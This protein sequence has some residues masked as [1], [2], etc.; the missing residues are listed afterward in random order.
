MSEEYM[1]MPELQEPV[2]MSSQD[3]HPEEEFPSED[4]EEDE[5]LGFSERRGNDGIFQLLHKI[6]NIPRTIR[7]GNVDKTELGHLDISIRG[8]LNIAQLGQTFGHPI[9]AGYYASLA[10]INTETSMSKKGWLLQQAISRR[11][12]RMV[13]S[14]FGSSGESP[15]GSNVSSQGLP[16]KTSS[17]KFKWFGRS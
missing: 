15:Y 8:C 13:S 7:V 6:I 2:P 12:E 16:E 10:N 5:F 11:S 9:F 3:F 4:R 1:P 14:G 17:G